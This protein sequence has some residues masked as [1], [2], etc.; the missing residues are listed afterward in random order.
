MTTY[1]T[2]EQLQT[3]TEQ[4]VFDHVVAHLLRQGVKSLDA[5]G[6]CAYRGLNGTACP[7]GCL[8]PDKYYMLKFEHEC[9]EDLVTRPC[10]MNPATIA[11]SR[12]APLLSDLQMA[13]DDSEPDEW[14]DELLKI[15][16]KRRLAIP[17]GLLQSML[18]ME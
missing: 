13:H 8:I 15:A 2:L 5:D 11:L 12:F 16:D 9:V 4:D 1:P 7:V 14:P 17:G 18:A 6:S 3:W 10:F